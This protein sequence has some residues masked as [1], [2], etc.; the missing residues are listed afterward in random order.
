M[1]GA[2]WSEVGPQDS[3][4]AGFVVSGGV[5]QGSPLSGA[6]FAAASIPL[7]RMLEQAFGSDRTFAYADDVALVL[8]S[9]ADLRRVADIMERYHEATGLQVKPSKC[10]IIP[11]KRDERGPE[12]TKQRYRALIAEC[13]PAWRDFKVVDKATYLGV[14]LGPGATRTDQWAAP[15]DKLRRRIGEL[16]SG[17]L[18]PSLS[19]KLF[20]SRIASVVSY[21]GQVV[22][23]PREIDAEFCNAVTRLWHFPVKA[24]PAAALRPLR[25]AGAPI[26]AHLADGLRSTFQTSQRRFAAHAEAALADL[27]RARQEHDTLAALARGGRHADERVWSAPA[28]C[29]EL[30]ALDTSDAAAEAGHRAKALRK[31]RRRCMA[32]SRR[33]DDAPREECHEEAAAAL[34]PRLARWAEALEMEPASLRDAAAKSLASLSACAPAIVVAALRSW[35]DAWPTTARRGRAI[36][37]CPCCGRRQRDELGHLVMCRALLKAVA[38]ATEIRVPRDAREALCMCDSPRILASCEKFARPRQRELF[39]AVQVETYQ[40]LAGLADDAAG[41][42]RG[43]RRRLAAAARHARRRLGGA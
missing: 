40:S 20:G 4:G 32:A 9:I 11:L 23:A 19:S 21:V 8:R 17:R 26:P 33:G 36:A 24:L 43:R 6:I 35:C 34:A 15:L 14:L 39:L 2:A 18:A 16:A 30:S 31:L 22:P 5:P 37:S 13:V 7:L 3:D 41:G 29:E 38:K 25:M 10:V 27:Q 12:A 28:I 1:L 42:E